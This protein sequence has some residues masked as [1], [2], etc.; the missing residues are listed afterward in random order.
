LEAARVADV[1]FAH[2]T[3]ATFCDDEGISYQPFEDFSRMLLSVREFSR[4]GH[5][6]A[7]L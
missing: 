4:N 2:S 5:R 7:E 3:L 6:E 1:I